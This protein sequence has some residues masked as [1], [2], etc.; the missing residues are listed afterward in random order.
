MVEQWNKNNPVQPEVDGWGVEVAPVLSSYPSPP[1][2]AQQWE[3][4]IHAQSEV[5]EAILAASV[6]HIYVFDR[7]GR[8]Q[9]VSQGGAEIMGYD[10]EE[11]LG[12]TWGE[13]GLPV[14]QMH[15]VDAQRETVMAT[16]Q[17]IKA[18]IQYTG[19]HGT[20]DYEYILTPWRTSDQRTV[21]VIAISRDVTDRKRAEREREATKQQVTNLL[22]SITY[23]FIAFDYEWRY[24]YVNAA[25]AKMAGR[26]PQELLG[27]R[28]QEVFP[29]VLSQNADMAQH[30]ERAMRERVTVHFE[31]FSTPLKRWVEMTAFP[32]PEGI[33]VFFRDVG[34]RKQAED[35]LRQREHEF[36][37]LVENTPDI[38]IRYDRHLRH[39]YVNPTIEQALG[40]PR[41]D[42][43]GKTGAELGFTSA[44]S[45]NWDT[46]L[47]QVFETGEASTLEFEFPNL[48]Q[49]MRA[50]QAQFVPEII[51][52]DA[53]QTVLAVVRDVTEYKGVEQELRDSEE[54]LRLAMDAG[55]MGAWEWN[56]DTN[57]QRWDVNQYK[58]FGVDKDQ[59]ELDADTFFNFVHPD[60]W[61][62]V[63]ETNARVLSEASSYR[64]E[65]RI[66]QPNGRVRWLSSQGMVVQGR[67]GKPV[68]MIGVN[69]DVT[70]RKLAEEAL[71]SSENRYRTLANAVSQLMWTNDAAGQVQFFNQTWL[72]YT[73]M[74][75]EES[76]KQ[77]A[78]KIHPDDWPIIR[79]ARAQSLEKGEAY[80]MEMR[81]QRF[82]QTYRWHLARVVPLKDEDGQVISWFGTAM[83]IHER[84]QAEEERDRLLQLEQAARTQAETANRIKDEFL[85]VLSH[86]LRSPLNPILGWTKLLQTRQLDSTAI[87]RALDT[88]ERNAKLQA[89]LIEDL[90]DISRILRGKLT[91][92]VGVV[93]LTNIIEAALETVRLAAEAKHITIQTRFLPDVG[94]VSGDGARLQQ[95]VWNL[96]SNAVKF[97]P[98]G[99]RVEV[100]LEQVGTEACIIV[101][102]SG[103]GIKPEFL[104]HVFDHFRQEDGTTTRQFG[105][106]GLGLAIVRHLTELHGGSVRAE[107]PGEGLG[108]T[109]IA[110]L[111]VLSPSAQQ[112]IARSALRARS[113]C[114]TPRA[115][116]ENLR[117]LAVDDE[118]DMRELI[119]TVLEQS[120]AMVQIAASAQEGL[121][122]LADFKPDILISDIGMPEMDGYSFLRQVR[123]LPEDQGGQI[124]AIALTAYAGE[125]NHQRALAVGFQRHL[126]K[127]V[128]P[129]VLIEAITQVLENR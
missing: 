101:Q 79:A 39:L 80:E 5:L 9:Y 103:K 63:Q 15:R 24:T 19:I 82:D 25:A 53:I 96:L 69:F 99:G 33:S 32:S 21:G 28:W 14:D 36:R 45:Q 26:S 55:H 95:I 77:W 57:V 87:Q 83:D 50:Y 97:T 109:F 37:T 104:P 94:P 98:N 23:G 11:L 120:G 20:H 1:E 108:A 3:G 38:I 123:N 107:S 27:R 8:Y 35:S 93:N 118:A 71:R 10:P 51:E 89:Q 64:T 115:C 44:T 61:P 6:D 2:L 102:D 67:D 12:K 40:L 105:G 62:H 75:L 18:E 106:L 47:R 60:D 56:L 30:F 119:H 122:A 48:A 100:C 13:A 42:F 46:V 114:L 58:I 112:A 91:L 59:I 43:I 41:Q 88:I 17:P 121:S 129:E 125:A 54:R 70:D 31:T 124:P 78:K 68:R 86:E 116:L 34:D 65:F 126:S 72:D 117:I 110:Q 49:Q 52:G 127:P 73:G 92:N 29:D 81:L 85:A 128:E 66:I 22:E 16:G 4:Q 76:L 84:K 7:A 113:R 90:L 111:P 74:S